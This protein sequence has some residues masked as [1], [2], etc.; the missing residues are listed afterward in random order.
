MGK[1]PK[2]TSLQE[3]EHLSTNFSGYTYFENVEDFLK[4]VF[5]IIY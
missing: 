1:R 4:L 3:T 2:M 5:K